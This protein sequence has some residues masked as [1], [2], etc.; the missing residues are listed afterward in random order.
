MPSYLRLQLAGGLGEN[1]KH[2]FVLNRL[3]RGSHEK[4]GPPSRIDRRHGGGCQR[5]S[6]LESHTKISCSK[7]TRRKKRD[8]DKNDAQQQ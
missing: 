2:E 7:K 5:S 8:T 3:S 4:K 6:N 1:S